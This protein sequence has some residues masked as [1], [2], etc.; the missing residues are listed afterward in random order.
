MS[1]SYDAWLCWLEK[2]P[3]QKRQSVANFIRKCDLGTPEG[4]T[5]LTQEMMARVAEGELPPGVSSDLR[6]WVG[7]VHEQLVSI[8]LT[9]GNKAD[10][11]IMQQFNLLVEKRDDLDLHG[12]IEAAPLKI[13]AVRSP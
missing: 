6:A 10:T 5:K 7:I 11:N 8:H 3:I 2:V 9:T 12:V 4:V 1:A 13:P